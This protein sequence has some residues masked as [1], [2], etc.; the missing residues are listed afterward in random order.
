MKN[1][2]KFIVA[3]LSS[4]AL[5]SCGGSNIEVPPSSNEIDKTLYPNYVE[6]FESLTYEFDENNIVDP[7][8]KG[9]VIYNESVLL[10]KNEDTGL[11]S[12]NLMFK[13]KKIIS[14]R[15][16]TLKEDVFKLNTDFTLNENRI[17]RTENSNIPYRTQAQLTGA[18]VPDGFR[19]VNSISNQLTDIQK[20]AGG[21]IYTES[22][23]YYGSQIWVS[24]VY[25]IE[26]IN[27][28]IDKYP[29]YDV[30]KLSNLTCK[31]SNREKIKVVGLGDSVLEG[32]SSSGKFNH[33]PFMDDFITMT[34]NELAKSYD[35]E[36]E[37]KNLSVGGKM[38]SWGSQNEQIQNVIKENPD[39]F[40]LHFGINDLGANRGIMQYS[41]DMES[42]VLRVKQALPNCEILLLSPFGPNPIV[43]DYTKLQDYVDA[44]KYLEETY[45]G[46][47][48][49][50]VFNLSQIMCE[51]K[52][53]LDMSANGIN[54]VNDYASRLY[55]EAILST[56]SNK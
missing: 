45:D 51:N 29:K 2:N 16:Y 35:T 50:D 21:T 19:L 52:N 17:I 11:I 49:I 25:D 41:D 4:A 22:P 26:E 56:I 31:L 10:T 30:T 15:D 38:S 28:N 33:E 23:F 46:V 24:Y 18:E 39:L 40:V 5:A 43:Y 27:S 1:N 34:C 54:H 20:F 7:F 9:N 32:C 14:V 53:Y 55:A 36:V 13:P 12:G 6:D 47:K 42:V 3:L 44:L 48:L 37:L 8:W